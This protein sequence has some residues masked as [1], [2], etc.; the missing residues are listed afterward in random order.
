MI[1]PRI[2]LS[3]TVPGKCKAPSS[4]PEKN[5]NDKDL[6]DGHAKYVDLIIMQCTYVL[7]SHP[8]SHR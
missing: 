1:G 4:I 5:M 6:T 3:D 8:V 7:S 2:R